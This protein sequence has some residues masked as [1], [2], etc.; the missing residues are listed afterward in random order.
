MARNDQLNVSGSFLWEIVAHA[1]SAVVTSWKLV[2]D[3][4]Y[5]SWNILVYVVSSKIIPY[6]VNLVLL[7][8]V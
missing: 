1:H 3:V 6:L 7:N 8:L 2:S 4:V 5:L